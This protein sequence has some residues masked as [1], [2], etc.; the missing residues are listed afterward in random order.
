MGYADPSD[1]APAVSGG[2][3]SSAY[4]MRSVAIVV[5]VPDLDG[6]ASVLFAGVLTGLVQSFGTDAIVAFDF[7][8]GFEVCAA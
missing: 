6:G 4:Q 8:V 3:S 2:R 1:A 7:P 5:N